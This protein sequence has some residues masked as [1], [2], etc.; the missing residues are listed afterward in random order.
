[1]PVDKPHIFHIEDS[2]FSSVISLFTNIRLVGDESS[3]GNNLNYE[4]TWRVIRYM[5]L[6]SMKFIII[7]AHWGPLS[8]CTKC[9]ASLIVLCCCPLA[10][11]TIT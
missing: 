3:G 7:F 10:P 6:F 4:L 1:M 9:P 11:G 2:M 8:S 5:G